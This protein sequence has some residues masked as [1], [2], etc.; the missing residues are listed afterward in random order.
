MTTKKQTKLNDYM[1]SQRMRTYVHVLNSM[2]VLGNHSKTERITGV[3]RQAFYW[4]MRHNPNFEEW[5]LRESR[6]IF[7]QNITKTVYSCQNEANKGNVQAMDKIFKIMGWLGDDKI[8][9]SLNVKIVPDR[10]FVLTDSI[11]Y[12]NNGHA[13][14]NGNGAGG[15][16]TDK[17][18][19]GN[20]FK[21]TV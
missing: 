12:G 20:R 2:E 4:Q 14:S 15:M 3:S 21:E 18:V 5:Y 1:P 16:D 7:K 8:E 17:G 6:A 9:Q 10:K 11:R 19:T 13:D